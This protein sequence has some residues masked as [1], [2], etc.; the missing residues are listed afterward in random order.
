MTKDISSR[1]DIIDM[2]RG[3]A[4]LLVVIRHIQLRIPFDELLNHI[5]EQLI[6]ALFIS[7]NDYHNDV[8]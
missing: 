5:P 7:G 6:N 4:I 1:Y 2:L 8:S 3:V